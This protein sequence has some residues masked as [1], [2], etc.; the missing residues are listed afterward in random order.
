MHLYS[1]VSSHDQPHKIIK[2]YN[3]G[4]HLIDF[5]E[6]I[7]IG[8]GYVVDMDELE[9][10]WTKHGYLLFSYDGLVGGATMYYIMVLETSLSSTQWVRLNEHDNSLDNY[11]KPFMILLKKRF[12]Q[13]LRTRKIIKE[14]KQEARR[15]VDNTNKEYEE[16][17][18]L[19]ML[20]RVMPM[21][22]GEEIYWFRD[23]EQ[24][25]LE[26]AIEETKKALDC[27][28][29]SEAETFTSSIEEIMNKQ[30]C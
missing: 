18:L 2:H 25:L 26:V 27:K 21:K 15:R 10:K 3:I 23:Y 29:R 7:T 17:I 14:Y 1:F 11:S 24:A 13:R 5:K 8:Q 28:V 9:E 22:K 4:G 20:E 6:H 19:T 16:Q 12:L 30:C